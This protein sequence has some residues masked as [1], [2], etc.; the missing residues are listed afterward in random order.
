MMLTTRKRK[1]SFLE[2]KQI[3]N[4]QLSIQLSLDGFSFCIIDLNLRELIHFESFQFD[5][6]ASNSVDL[7]LKIKQIFKKVDELNIPFKSVNVIQ[8]N[9]LNS[10]IPKALFNEKESKHYLEFNNKTFESDYYVNDEIDNQDM[11]NVYVPYVNINNYFIDKFGSFTYKHG[12]SILVDKLLNYYSNPSNKVVFI[13]L[14]KFEF[15]LIVS[16]HKKLELYNSFEYTTKEDFL[17]YLLFTLEQLKI[18]KETIEVK[19][20]GNITKEAILFKE[21]SKYI[22]NIRLIED[23]LQIPTN[24]DLTRDL[25]RSNFILFHFI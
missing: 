3:E 16:D 15:E 20:I 25:K 23:R 22:S 11:V 8:L 2:I 18:N 19:F 1:N 14:S 9:H 6:R 24:L 7:L 12:A 4:K 21:T 5:K 13:H 17:Y 10:F